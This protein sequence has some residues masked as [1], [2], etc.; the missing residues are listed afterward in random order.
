MTDVKE[1]KEL[2]ARKV[3]GIWTE[4]FKMGKGPGR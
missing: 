2:V 1:E 4:T 3:S